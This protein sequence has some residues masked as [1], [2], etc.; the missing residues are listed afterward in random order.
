MTLTLGA[1]HGSVPLVWDAHC[2]VPLLPDQDLAHLERHRKAGANFVSINVGMDFT[3]LAQVVRVIAGFRAWITRHSDGFILAETIDDVL[4]AKTTGRL[5]IAFDLEGSAML[6]DDLAMVRLFCD[7]GVRQIHLAY[8]RDNSIAGG[9]HGS[10]SG[11]TALGRAVVREI[12]AVGMMMDCSHSSKRTSLDIVELS[13]KPVVFSHSNARALQ[14]HPRNIDDEQIRACAATDGVIGICGIS[15]FLGVGGTSTAN[16]VRHI[17]YVSQLVGS[18]H[19]GLGLDYVFNQ[20][21]SDLPT[22]LDPHD[23]WPPAYEYRLATGEIV[24]PEQLP[25]IATALRARGY[26][27]QDIE[28]I[29]GGNFL[30]VARATWSETS[31]N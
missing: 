23:W 9:C 8:N 19:V 3:P 12:N 5:S 2:C 11:L 27:Q 20:Q 4:L 29:M 15:E 14:D 16:V 28:G 26:V 22:G 31:K 30:R 1:E 17:D 21:H 10:G 7:L 24:T 6:Q 18:R 25:E 13:T